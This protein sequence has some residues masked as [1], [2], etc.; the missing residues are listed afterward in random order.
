MVT[1]PTLERGFPTPGGGSYCSTS[2]RRATLDRINQQEPPMKHTQHARLLTAILGLL[3]SIHSQGQDLK[4]LHL[5]Q[6]DADTLVQQAKAAHFSGSIL[7]YQGTTRLLQW[8]Q[9]YSNAAAKTVNMSH[10]RY[11]IGSIG[12]NLTAILMMQLV[13]KGVVHLD[14]T[15]NTYL[16]ANFRLVH[17]TTAT[18]RQLLNMTAGLG[19]YFDSPAYADSLRRTADLLRLVVNTKPVNDTPGRQFKYSNASFIVLAGILEHYYHQ[20]YQ[21]LVQ[22][23]LLLP[24]G[25]NRIADYPDAVGYSLTNGEWVVGAD[26][27][28]NWSAAGGIR[29]SAPEW[30][31][32]VSALRAGKYLEP[33]TIQTMWSISSHPE[34]DPPFVNYGLGWMVES[35]G[36]IQLRGHNGGVRGFQAAYRYL[37]DDDVY[38]YVFSNQENGAEALFMQQLVYLFRQKGVHFD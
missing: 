19:D 31:A 8:Q 2:G 24:A 29:L 36:G 38:L 30:H 3:T 6:A 25:V 15:A 35:P 33:R 23:K 10:T 32:V 16:P 18:V 26:N 28:A 7:L 13:E 4:P 17:N 22:K 11:N 34:T 5:T 9:G 12:K 21:Q 1:L 20:S 14:S 37:P 27:K